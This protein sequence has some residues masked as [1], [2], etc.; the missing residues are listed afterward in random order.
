V[1]A[2]APQYD[3]KIG[4]TCFAR[5]RRDA[6]TLKTQLALCFGAIAA[7][8]LLAEVGLR[9]VSPIPIHDLL[10][11]PYNEDRVQQIVDGNTYLRFDQHLGWA[12][13]PSFVRRSSGQV[14]RTNSIGMRAEREYP[15]DAPA[16]VSR[17]AAFGDSFTYCTEV[18]QTAC[19]VPQLE[20]AWPNTEILNYGV[21]GYGP[22][23]A[24]L[25]YQRDGQA[26]QPCAVLIGYFVEDIDR[27][28]S[29]FRPFTS[30]DDS[31]IMSKPRFLLD[32]D[33]LAL[34]P[35]GVTTPSQV[36]DVAWVEQTLGAHDAWF[37]PGTFVESP[38]DRSR[39]I[40]L[41]RTAAYR[42]AR[43][44]LER[45]TD[46]YPLYDDQQEAYQVT[47]RILIEFA[48]QVRAAG[49]TPVVIVFPGERDIVGYQRG[50]RV[51]DRLLSWLAEE[52]VPTVDLMDVLS[53][54]LEHQSI[55]ELFGEGRHY[56]AS[57]N[58]VVARA[59]AKTLPSLTGSTC[60][61]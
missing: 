24:W 33:G 5:G 50:V 53:G 27:V 18:T 2:T 11:F 47:G 12:P 46:S 3:D 49:A 59:L 25:R 55:G 51:Y 14:F 44:A 32:G 13:A 60:A 31:V 57:G 58:A 21:P 37:F 38:F 6:R 30:P 26:Y 4:A 28:V 40:R 16:G 54:E 23:Q 17:I 35:S 7:V 43:A 42:H 10:P 61:E 36:E 41:A 52:D 56:S 48:E 22:D 29:R 39:L 45:D 8:V 1:S 34:L 9:F 19:W 15:W 20:S